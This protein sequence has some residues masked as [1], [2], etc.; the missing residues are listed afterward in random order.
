MLARYPETIKLVFKNFPLRNHT[1][2]AKAAAAALAA[3]AQ[4]K[5]WPFHKALFDNAR[6][7]SDD[8]IRQ[9]AAQL[10]LDMDKFEA[11]MESQATKELIARDVKEG[12]Q[13]GVRGTPTIFINGIRLTQRNLRG[14]QKVIDAELKNNQ[15]QKSGC[16]KN[17]V[18]ED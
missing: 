15:Q 6:R 2:A 7:L 13:A 16:S 3:Q 5:F 14:F 18:T 1:Y 11:D 10:S 8:K 4:G 9:I 17:S 12:K